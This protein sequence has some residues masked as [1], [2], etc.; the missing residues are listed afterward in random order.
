MTIIS[1]IF[2]LLSCA[3]NLKQY[4]S[5]LYSRSFTFILYTLSFLSYKVL[6]LNTLNKGIGI[7]GG[8]FTVTSI[9]SSFN[10]FIYLITFFILFLNTHYDRR[11]WRNQDNKILYSIFY[12][13]N[14]IQNTDD[15]KY[16][17]IEYSLIILFIITG[18]Q[19]LMA[20]SDVISVFI[21]IELQSYGLYIL[22]TVYRNSELSTSSGLTYFLLGGLASCFILLS[23]SLLYANS[24]CTSL[25]N[26]YIITTIYESI[27]EIN[28]EYNIDM[29]SW[30][31]SYYL[32]IS[33]I[34]MIIGFLIKISA[35]PFHFWSPDVYDGVPT[36]VTTFI[37]I[38]PKISILIFVL[39][40]VINMDRN[41][42]Q[43][44]LSTILLT[45]S[46]LSLVIGTVLGLAQSRIKRLYAYST[47]SHIGFL[48]LALS[49][50]TREST[51]AF[52]F[53]LTQYSISNLNAFLILIAIGYSLYTYIYNEN[54][55]NIRKQVNDKELNNS[56]IQLIDQL[57]GYFY[58]NPVL[59]L[60]LAITLFSF[61]G[62]PPLVGFFA[63]LMVLSSS[64]DNGYVFMAIIGILTS[65]ISAVYY[66][67]IIK[68]VFFDENIY[69]VNKNVYSTSSIDGS[70]FS[71]IIILSSIKCVI[72]SILTLIILLFMFIPTEFLNF[73]LILSMI[74][75]D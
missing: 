1:L 61:A 73:L 45:S 10:L 51:Q 62:I 30:Y 26:F 75:L 19:F 9:N 56:P 42:Y 11:I 43:H 64:I 14:K 49:N 41:I 48:L 70:K 16:K 60:S 72:I 58:I 52:L 20:S 17:V 37:S 15:Y 47:I 25:E 12:I 50:E 74:L 55:S 44:N 65:V 23:T 29:W 39:D 3:V 63:K 68:K 38:M 4:F 22:C 36:I 6:Y 28:I 57:K 27:K 66:L 35:A 34:I 54:H 24:G 67:V 69:L 59:S 31:S 18:G 13:S 53:Y 71:Q 33:M 46:L 2:I 40:L 21:S 8:L 32:Y 7:F 5:I